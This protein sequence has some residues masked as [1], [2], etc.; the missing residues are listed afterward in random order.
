M[1]VAGEKIKWGVLGCACIA[2]EQF[3]P[4]IQKSSNGLLWGVASRTPEKQ[5]QLKEEFHVEHI[6]ESYDALLD[7]PEID[8][9]YIPLPNH[10]H[11]EWVIKALDKK[12]HVLCEK[13]IALNADEAE[14][15]IEAS[16]RNGVLLMEAFAY[17]N[18]EL[19]RKVHEILASGILGKVRNVQV[20]FQF[21]VK[22]ADDI[23]LD[24]KR[25]GGA[26]LDLGCY[27][28]S[29]IRSIMGSEPTEVQAMLNRHPS[30]VDDNNTIMLRFDNQAS[31]TAFISLSGR[32]DSDRCIVGTRGLLLIPAFFNFEGKKELLLK[33]QKGVERIPSTVPAPTAWKLNILVKASWREPR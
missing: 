16:L 30:G 3:I 26:I 17:L 27:A 7:D 20:R 6:Y 8:A 19:M 9:V 14:R 5:T 1:K 10:M 12:K 24:P 25:G 29:F 32:T 18:G 23:R 13:P 33:K 31:A 28:V 4:S 2:V 11:C 22:T 15:M 21:P